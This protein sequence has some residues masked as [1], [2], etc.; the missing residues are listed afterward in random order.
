MDVFEPLTQEQNQLY[1]LEMITFVVGSSSQNKTK[2]Q[3]NSNNQRY[4]EKRSNFN[5][6]V[7]ATRNEENMFIPK[8]TCDLVLR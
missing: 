5:H 2:K 7:V 3:Q 1:R 4:N 8:K 6:G